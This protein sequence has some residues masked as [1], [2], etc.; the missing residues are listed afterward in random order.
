MLHIT[1]LRIRYNYIYIYEIDASITNIEMP[2]II[3]V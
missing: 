3:N 2:C 1:I